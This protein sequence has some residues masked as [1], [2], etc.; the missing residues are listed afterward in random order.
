MSNNKKTTEQTYVDIL[1]MDCAGMFDAQA[2][3]D[4]AGL[5]DNLPSP[6]QDKDQEAVYDFLIKEVDF[7]DGGVDGDELFLDAGRQTGLATP[8]DADPRDLFGVGG[9]GGGGSG[10][11]DEQSDDIY[12]TD[13][14]TDCSGSGSDEEEEEEEYRPC[15]PAVAPHVLLRRATELMVA[16]TRYEKDIHE[17]LWYETCVQIPAWRTHTTAT[18]PPFIRAAA[19]DLC[20]VWCCVVV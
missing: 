7:G 17:C 11:E 15:P 8:R 20:V 3:E 10:G 14:D 1:A 12:D 2:G 9:G 16:Q 6:R 13:T 5:V 4:E 19:A 18:T